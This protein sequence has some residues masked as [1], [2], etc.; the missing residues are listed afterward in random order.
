MG[1]FDQGMF[2]NFFNTGQQ[3]TDFIPD[4]PPIEG[5][6]FGGESDFIKSNLRGTIESGGMNAF[7]QQ[8][9]ATGKKGIG[10]QARTAREG[11]REA[12]A[13][14]GFRGANVNAITG[15][16]EAEAG[17]VGEL[18]TGVAGL[19]E[20]GRAGAL[21]QLI[22]VN[23]FEGGMQLSK[24]QLEEGMRQFDITTEEGRR[25]FEKAYDLQ[26]RELD[27][28][29]EAQGGDFWDIVGGG[30]GLVGGMALG[31]AGG[32]LGNMLGNFIQGT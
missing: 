2:S 23:Q 28:M 13:S 12:G 25:Q 27:A 21:S 14:S 29:I 6:F 3:Q 7:L 1:M 11:V 22:G 17:A 24:A 26:E 5:D 9:L 31:G 4:A 8:M 32:A 18:E 20:Q 30:L 16:F 15:L 19:A 10:R